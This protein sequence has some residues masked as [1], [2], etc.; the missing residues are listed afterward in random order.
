MAG[1]RA[2]LAART[3]FVDAHLQ[4]ADAAML[5]PGTPLMQAGAPDR[6]LGWITPE[7]GVPTLFH[8]PVTRIGD[9]N[10]PEPVEVPVEAAPHPR[11]RLALRDELACWPSADGRLWTVDLR[12]SASSAVSVATLEGAVL[13][14]PWL[15]SDGPRAVWE[16]PGRVTLA[17]A[18]PQS[19]QLGVT[20]GVGM[21]PLRSVHSLLVAGKHWV[22]VV[23]QQLLT[24]DGAAREQL[25]EASPPAGTLVHSLMAPA[26]DGTPRLL[27]LHRDGGLTSLTMVRPL[28]GAQE[29][30]WREDPTPANLDGGDRPPLEPRMLLAD[31]ER[32]YL[33]HRKGLLVFS[34]A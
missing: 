1:A 25:F 29:T 26:A 32:L 12:R 33:V 31:R 3:G 7:G 13:A 9:L 10:R 22:T 27:T 18:P 2:V 19:G 21:P 15:E 20:A 23:A 4:H 30:L 17:L 14:L 5:V 34:Q 24:F 28:S 16:L 11:G 6:W 8:A